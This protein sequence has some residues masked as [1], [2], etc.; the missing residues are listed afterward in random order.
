MCSSDLRVDK[1]RKAWPPYRGTAT[2][3][4]DGVSAGRVA[5]RVCSQSDSRGT[6]QK[7]GESMDALHRVP[8]VD[9]LDREVAYDVESV[10]PLVKREES[11]SCVEIVINPRPEP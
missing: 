2:C 10:R 8:A 11:L 6:N 3:S 4:V 5:R 9:I 7:G 1:L